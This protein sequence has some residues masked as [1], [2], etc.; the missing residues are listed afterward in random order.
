MIIPGGIYYDNVH[1]DV[2]FS[3]IE[4]LSAYFNLYLILFTFSTL[5]CEPSSGVVQFK[6]ITCN[7]APEVVRGE[8]E[9]S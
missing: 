8:E 6:E 5:V 2:L 1:I 7:L 3:V 4:N 9:E